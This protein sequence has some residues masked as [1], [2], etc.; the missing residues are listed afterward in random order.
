ML[1]DSRLAQFHIAEASTR[2]PKEQDAL[3]IE[4]LSATPEGHLLIGFRN[5]IPQGKA[6][7][8]PLLN[9]NEVIE[10]KPA[11][12]GD[13]IQ[14]DLEGLGIRDMAY[15]DGFYFII[16]GSW[17]SGGK[18]QFYRWSGGSAEPQK[19]TVKHVGDYSPEAII[20]Y[21][22]KGFREIQ[23]LSDDGNRAVN[24]I[25]GKELG[26][27]RPNTFRSFWLIEK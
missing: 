9:P 26:D 20:I 27:S 1:R 3:N 23:I 10:D 16:A 2:A 19:L 25:P 4:G 8:I 18:F 22:E 5:P 15:F 7:L 13:A 6:L 17:H 24:G 14:L 12:F 11:L 21:P